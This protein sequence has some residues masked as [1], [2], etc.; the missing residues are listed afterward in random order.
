[1]YPKFKRCR[2][3]VLNK[4][5]RP[6]SFTKLNSTSQNSQLVNLFSALHQTFLSRGFFFCIICFFFFFPRLCS[7][8]NSNSEGLCNIIQER[9]PK[10]AVL[11]NLEDSCSMQI[12]LLKILFQCF[13]FL[14]HPSPTDISDV[15]CM[16]AKSVMSDSL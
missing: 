15:H 2:S 4:K 11:E 7:F 16:P 3:M 8:Q 5:E 10:N 12:L 9:G 13:L 14:P 6:N 1:M